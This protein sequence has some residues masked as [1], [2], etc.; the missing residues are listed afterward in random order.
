MLCVTLTDSPRTLASGGDH[1]GGVVSDIAAAIRRTAQREAAIGV[2]R[3]G[4]W[5]NVSPFGGKVRV[6]D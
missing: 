5:I 6:Y 1:I 2:E 3:S 4:I